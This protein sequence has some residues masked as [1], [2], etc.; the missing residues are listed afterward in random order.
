MINTKLFLFANFIL[1]INSELTYTF[2]ATYSPAST[3]QNGCEYSDTTVAKGFSALYLKSNEKCNN[4]QCKMQT[5]NNVVAAKL[6][7]VYSGCK[8][9]TQEEK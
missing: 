2:K 6:L 5:K 1:A 3:V 8:L 9:V 7:E 4:I